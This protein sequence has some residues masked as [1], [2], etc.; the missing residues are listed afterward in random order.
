MLSCTSVL[1][2]CSF[3]RLSSVVS[4]SSG[5]LKC[6]ISEDTRLNECSDVPRSYFGPASLDSFLASLLFSF[7]FSTPAYPTSYIFSN[8]NFPF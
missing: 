5:Q 2:H 3:Q 7:K 4:L 8:I 1:K 6:L